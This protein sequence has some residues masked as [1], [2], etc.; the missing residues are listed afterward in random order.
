M[1]TFTGVVLAGGASRRM[2]QDKALLNTGAGTM[3]DHMIKLL[4][5]VGASKIVVL[6]RGVGPGT[7]AD[8]HPHQG[9]AVALQ[10]FLTTQPKGSRHLV[11]PVDMPSLSVKLLSDL[12]CQSRWTHFKDYPLP[13]MAIA[14]L[15]PSQFSRKIRGLHLKNNA[16]LLPVP[17]S[18][19][20]C[21]SNINTPRDYNEF[22]EHAVIKRQALQ[23]CFR[24]SHK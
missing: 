11:V 21:F 5:L 23:G 16:T 15:A 6:G 8:V 17:P 2:G 3:L 14:N 10:D 7:L 20:H 1:D 22:Q 4:R 24:V 18:T 9:P 19:H 13:C 12:A